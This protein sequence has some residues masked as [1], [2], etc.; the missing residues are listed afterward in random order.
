MWS[1]VIV[2]RL[3]ELRPDIYGDWADQTTA[4]KAKQLAAALKP[5]GIE[6]MQVFRK[7]ETGAKANNRGIARDDITT[8]IDAAN[9]TRR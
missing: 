5:Y 6:T 4:A 1:H 3:A 2:D 8:A 7:T 9:P